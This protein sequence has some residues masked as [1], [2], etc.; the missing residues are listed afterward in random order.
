MHRIFVGLTGCQYTDLRLV[1]VRV[2]AIFALVLFVSIVRGHLSLYLARNAQLEITEGILVSA[3]HYKHAKGRRSR[4]PGYQIELSVDEDT[5][6]FYTRDRQAADLLRQ[7]VGQIITVGTVNVIETI[8]FDR[9]ERLVTVSLNGVTIR[10]DWRFI[11]GA[12]KME[13]YSRNFISLM[14]SLL[15]VVGSL[16]WVWL[17]L[18]THKA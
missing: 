7:H 4:N 1:L 18:K 8:F 6:N 15:F 12:Q 13:G 9:Q 10:E 17:I 14:V 11:D 2:V 16:V 5:V 3:P